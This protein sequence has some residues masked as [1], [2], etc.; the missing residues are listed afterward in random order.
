MSESYSKYS[1]SELFSMLSK[2]KPIAEKAFAEL[3]SRFSQRIYAY[4]LRVTGDENDARDIFQDVFLKFY[5]SAETHPNVLN[6][7]AYLITITRNLCLNYKRDTKKNLNIEDFTF[8]TNDSTFEQKEMMELIARA[9]EV[10]DTDYREAFV[11]RIYEGMS[12]QEIADI[13]GTTVSTIKNRVWRAKE[14]IKNVL[15]P[16]LEDMSN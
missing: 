1:D 9:L 4:C 11:L 7:G 12:Y 3:Y 10:L 5:N 6:V 2:G 14:K 16:Y 13:T 15:T 8:F